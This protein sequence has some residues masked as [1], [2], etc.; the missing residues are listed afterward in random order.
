MPHPDDVPAVTAVPEESRDETPAFL[1][2]LPWDR[3]VE[4]VVPGL[5]PPAGRRFTWNGGR[6]DAEVRAEDLQYRELDVPDWDDL[7]ARYRR[8]MP[9]HLKVRFLMRAPDD[10]VRPLLAEWNRAEDTDGVG[11]WPLTLVARHGLDAF[12]FAWTQAAA[13]PGLDGRLLVPYLDADVAAWMG[14][15]WDRPE[16]AWARAWLDVHGLDAVPYLATAALGRKARAPPAAAAAL[17]ALAD[18][19]G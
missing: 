15:R 10:I 6:W 17:R 2:E 12:P 8:R 13:R 14:E 11:P 18:A 16:N 19:H 7:L 3:P 9:R 1:T 4:P 5:K